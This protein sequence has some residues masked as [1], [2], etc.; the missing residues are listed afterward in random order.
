MTARA[1]FYAAPDDW[2]LHCSREW[3]SVYD[4]RDGS[5]VTRQWRGSRTWR[6]GRKAAEKL[7]EKM[8]SQCERCTT[9]KTPL[10]YVKVFGKIEHLCRACQPNVLTDSYLKEFWVGERGFS[11]ASAMARS[12]AADTLEKM[13]AARR[14]A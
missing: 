4:S 11:E 7:A 1:I 6:Y 3:W 13:E 5:K 14:V 8:N 9:R 12:A 10:D 2:P